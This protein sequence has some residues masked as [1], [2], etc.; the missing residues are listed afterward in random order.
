MTSSLALFGPV[1]AWQMGRYD[2]LAVIAIPAAVSALAVLGSPLHIM[3]S[4]GLSLLAFT[5][6]FRIIPGTRDLF[7]NAGLGGFDMNKQPGPKV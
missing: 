6:A 4:V 3:A 1:R 2:R 7:L 5:V